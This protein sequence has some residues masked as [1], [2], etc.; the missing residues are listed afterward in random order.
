MSN[1]AALLANHDFDNYS[2]LVPFLEPLP[3]TKRKSLRAVVQEGYTAA[4]TAL[5]TQQHEPQLQPWLCVVH[6]GCIWW[7]Y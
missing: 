5:Q 6:P 2:K 1:Y 4:R 7:P 3:D